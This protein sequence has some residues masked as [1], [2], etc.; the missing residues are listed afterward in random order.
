[1]KCA[2]IWLPFNEPSMPP[3]GI[4]VL[5]GYLRKKRYDV[6]PVDLNV[7]FYQKM[8]DFYCH[9]PRK[10]AT[11]F[12]TWSC[13][14]MFQ[15]AA[16]A[17]AFPDLMN[18]PVFPLWEE[19]SV[20]VNL[21]D[22]LLQES[23]KIASRFDFVGISVT[24]TNFMAS[25]ALSKM[26]KGKDPDT[27]IAWGGPTIREDQGNEKLSR[28]DCVDFL[29]K[30]PGERPLEQILME[31]SQ[32]KTLIRLKQK[33]INNE[34][35]ANTKSCP[36]FSFF[37]FRSYD[38][39]TFPVQTSTGCPWAK[40]AFCHESEPG[41]QIFPMEYVAECID[42]ITAISNNGSIFFVDSC[43]NWDIDRLMQI[44][45]LFSHGKSRKWTCMARSERLSEPIMKQ[46]KSAGCE[47]IFI[48][49]ETFSDA[50]LTA[51]KKGSSKLDHL[52]AFRLGRE[53]GIQIAG[54]FLTG[55][56]G[57]TRKNIAEDI[58][59]LER[60]GHLWHNCLFWLSPYTAMPGSEIFQH[61]GQFG[62][63]IHEYGDETR[64]LP[65]TVAGFVPV[66]NHHW[67]YLDDEKNDDAEILR[68]HHQLSLRIQA[69]QETA[70]PV[71]YIRKTWR[72]LT[73]FGKTREGKAMKP[74]QLSRVEADIL[75][76][77]HAITTVRQL[78]ADMGQN[79]E[80]LV[81]AL[82]KLENRGW[83]ARSRNRI[84]RTVS[85]QNRRQNSAIKQ[86]TGEKL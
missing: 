22:L 8:K 82:N 23:E 75:Q 72:G 86:R 34:Q 77:C 52:Q 65:E 27:G 1:M 80:Q 64:E 4:A 73:A 28:L 19:R 78:A 12:N 67:A 7:A 55:F 5:T 41:R 63:R 29:I 14:A 15:H 31:V 49:L 21:K 10:V 39:L 59:V 35:P 30:G 40:C 13:H 11:L 76:R 69:V 56:P 6:Y 26:I 81:S 20:Y 62:I 32:G 18:P 58:Q 50:T 3:L 84:I 45:G 70:L 44:C 85:F 60:Y 54:N 17:L 33:K 42:H 37:P 83:I 43:L 48:G 38:H 71:W 46:M 9:H 36:D 53:L 25:V 16:A 24:S 61:P 66:W 74:Q 68:Q 2:L 51:M 79:S 57:E 47:R